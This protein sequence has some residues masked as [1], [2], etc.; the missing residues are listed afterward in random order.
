MT[1]PKN[2]FRTLLIAGTM[3]AGTVLGAGAATASPP[4]GFSAQDYKGDYRHWADCENQAKVYRAQG[5]R[6]ACT[7]SDD[8][9]HEGDLYAKF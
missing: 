5:I 8:W 4:P 9:A 3:T 7:P 1:T 2:L 6:A